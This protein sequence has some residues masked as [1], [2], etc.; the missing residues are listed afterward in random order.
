MGVSYAPYPDYKKSGVEWLDVVPRDWVVSKVKFLAPFQVGWTPPTNV[1][2]NFIGSNLWAN[3]SDLKG[4]YIERTAK[5][6]SD[7][8]AKS[9]SME[10]SPKGSLLYSFKLSV[11]AVSFASQDMY[12]NEAIASFLEGGELPLSYMYYA[13]PKFVIEN[14]STNIYGA[15][16]LNQELINNAFLLAPSYEEA[17]II[18]NF[19]DHETAKID[20]LIEKQQQLI[21]LL[22]EKHEAMVVHTMLKGL[23]KKALMKGSG[24]EW[25]GDIPE[26]WDVLKTKRLFSLECHPSPSN[27]D[28]ELLSV[29]TNIG[30][31]PRKDLEQKGNKA[32]TTDGYWVVKKGDLI[33]NKLLAWMGAVGYSAY[34]GVTSPAYDILRKRRPL[35]VKFYH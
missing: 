34:D 18:A 30:V 3:I 31:R 5:N 29:Y 13:L 24:A 9:A 27:N 23:N 6:I 25:L 15:R 17:E 28:M 7:D 35:N 19:L 32:S 8:A 22:K 10:I 21:K 33:V 2:A 1:D 11:G 12:T 14:A 20:I 26:H 16:I 4:K